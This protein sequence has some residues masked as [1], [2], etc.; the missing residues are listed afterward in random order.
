MKEFSCF[1]AEDDRVAMINCSPEDRILVKIKD[2]ILTKNNIETLTRDYGYDSFDKCMDA[3]IVDAR[4]HDMQEKMSN[5]ERRFGRVYL[6]N[7]K[8]A[9]TFQFKQRG[10]SSICAHETAVMRSIALKYV[11]HHMI[12]IP[13]RVQDQW[14]LSVVHPKLKRIQVLNSYKPLNAAIVPAVRNMVQGLECY[15]DHIDA[16]NK[17]EYSWW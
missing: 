13:M 6:E 4:I 15:F 8:M 14:F 1:M 16:D 3:K 12:F 5:D 9:A 2:S 7:T 17:K 10:E 11:E